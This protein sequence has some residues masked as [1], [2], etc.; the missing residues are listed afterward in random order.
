MPCDDG[1]AFDG[2]DGFVIAKI[3]AKAIRKFL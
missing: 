1:S 2:S 3:L